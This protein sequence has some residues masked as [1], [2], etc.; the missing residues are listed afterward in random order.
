MTEATHAKLWSQR[1]H[2]LAHFV[3]GKKALGGNIPMD[4]QQQSGIFA[5]VIGHVCGLAIFNIYLLI[6]RSTKIGNSVLYSKSTYSKASLVKEFYH[7]LKCMLECI[8]GV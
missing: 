4:V 3:L 5:H 1:P 6:G 8:L 7:C 2:Q